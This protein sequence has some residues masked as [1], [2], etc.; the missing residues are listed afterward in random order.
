MSRV[1]VVTLVAFS[2]LMCL[3]TSAA[4]YCS[5]PCRP[6]A[7]GK[8]NDGTT[9]YFTHD[10]SMNDLW[11]GFMN[12]VNLWGVE[13]STIG[14]SISL[15]EGVGDWTV[16]LDDTLG[17]GTAGQTNFADKTVRINPNYLSYFTAIALHEIGHTLLLDDVTSTSCANLTVMYFTIGG[18]PGDITSADDCTMQH[19]YFIRDESPIVLTLESGFPELT[20]PEVLFDLT[21]CGTPQLVGWTKPDVREGFL[22]LDRDGNGK[23]TSGAEMFGNHTPFPGASTEFVAVNGFQALAAYDEARNG[24]DRDGWI[25]SADQVFS[26]LRV[27]LDDNHN[28]V[29][30]ANEMKTLAELGIVAI[31]LSARESPKRDRFGNEMRYVASFL[32]RT[33]SG[34]VVTRRAVD[35]YFVHQ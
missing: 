33:A 3:S 30:E 32:L 2:L 27:W 15:A 26:S 34:E 12:N 6:Y 20:G 28:G 11:S 29:S 10:S 21:N 14:S 22:V 5:D 19:V 24:G 35:V 7:L 13:M 1:T 4:A 23:I 18:N 16:M 17:G 9:V 31:S 8:L 25:T